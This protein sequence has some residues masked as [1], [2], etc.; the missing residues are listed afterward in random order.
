VPDEFSSVAKP[1]VAGR[2]GHGGSGVAGK[3]L[4][5]RLRMWVQHGPYC[6]LL[7]RGAAFAMAR[8]ITRKQ[9]PGYSIVKPLLADR[10]GLE[11]GGP[12]RMFSKGKVIPAYECCREID[13]AN[14]ARQTIWSGA[15]DRRM[16][17]GKLRSEYVVEATSF[18]M[19]AD[20]TYDFVLACHVLE[21][22]ANPLRALH[23]WSR[24][25]KPGGLVVV[26]VPDK[27]WTFDRRRP[28]TSFDHL[29]ADFRS[30]IEEDDLTHLDEVLRLHDF[31]LE[32]PGGSWEDFRDRCFQN[33]TV[34][35]MHHHVFSPE[36]LIRMFAHARMQALSVAESQPNHIVAFAQKITGSV[37]EEVLSQNLGLL[38]KRSDLTSHNFW[39][40]KRPEHPP[41]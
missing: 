40:R 8:R 3:S 27:R 6:V 4:L 22:V 12:T 26:V 14:F 31:A 2:E 13:N 33:V 24:V 1:N 20:G 11:V 38:G 37:G 41:L 23:E 36:V 35:A 9:C 5:R 32:A 25:L 19:V 29:E 17:G 28:Y 15:A 39:R 21:H 10:R 7:L 34:R 18:P 30:N 16:F